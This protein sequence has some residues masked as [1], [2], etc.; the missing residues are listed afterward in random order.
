MIHIHMPHIS[1]HLIHWVLVGIASGVVT[2]ALLITPESII[3]FGTVGMLFATPIAVIISTVMA[4]RD[5]SKAASAAALVAEKLIVETKRVAETA[6]TQ[7]RKLDQIH[8]LVNSNLTAAMESELGAHKAGLVLMQEMVDLKR[9]SGKSPSAES[10]EAIKITG[11][12][13]AELRAQ[14]DDRIKQT[15]VANKEAK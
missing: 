13:V 11:A 5:A 1:L 4:R 2:A 10:L 15:V 14:L 6:E 8:T 7:G 9:L 3:S 12:K